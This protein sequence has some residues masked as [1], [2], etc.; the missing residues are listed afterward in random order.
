MDKRFQSVEAMIPPP[1]FGPKGQSAF[2]RYTGGGM[3]CLWV[4]E[5]EERQ[6]ESSRTL[7]FLKSYVDAAA[8]SIR[9][10]FT[11]CDFLKVVIPA[12]AGIQRSLDSGSPF[13][14][15]E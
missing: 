4:L 1:V 8:R 14:R 6:R 2:G 13:G 5:E 7:F 9:N 10:S 11:D 15:P 3:I 12:Y